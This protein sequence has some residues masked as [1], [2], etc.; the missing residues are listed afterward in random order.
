M[1]TETGESVSLPLGAVVLKA[2]G[3]TGWTEWSRKT[4]AVL[5]GVAQVSWSEMRREGKAVEYILK[6][7]I[8]YL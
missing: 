4:V 5:P 8:L 2:P 7:K 6:N 3:V 1:T